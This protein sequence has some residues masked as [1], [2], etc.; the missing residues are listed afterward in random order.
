MASLVDSPRSCSAARLDELVA[1]ATRLQKGAHRHC[2]VPMIDPEAAGHDNTTYGH[3][4]NA[5]YS[6]FAKH[7]SQDSDSLAHQRCGTFWLPQFNHFENQVVYSELETLLDRSSGPRITRAAWVPVCYELSDPCCSAASRASL[8]VLPLRVRN[9]PQTRQLNLELRSHVFSAL[10]VARSSGSQRRDAEVVFISNR[11]STNGRHLLGEPAKIAALERAA[12]QAGLGFSVLDPA[13]LSY[14]DEIVQLARARYVVGLFGSALHN[15]RFMAEG[16]IVLELHGALI[17]DFRNSGYW[18]LCNCRLGLRYVGLRTSY[19]VPRMV[20]GQAVYGPL[21]ALRPRSYAYLHH[22]AEISAT[23]LVAAFQMAV[24]GQFTELTQAYAK[25][26]EIFDNS[27]A[28]RQCFLTTMKSSPCPQT[29]TCRGR[30]LPARGK[31]RGRA[32]PREST[33]VHHDHQA[34]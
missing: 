33:R 23:T 2:V 32:L 11:R 29:A 5:I 14:R 21:D 8:G 31:G 7:I 1:R 28:V 20:K 19:A 15:C 34:G 10:G 17:N 22:S 18:T 16:T 26:D 9:V 6:F 4:W 24:R 12:T 30:S 13:L 3:V 25:D 27:S